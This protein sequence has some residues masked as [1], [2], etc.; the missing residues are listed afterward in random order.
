MGGGDHSV[1]GS[2]PPSKTSIIIPVLDEEKLIGVR[3]AE[4]ATAH[5]HEV[6]VVDGGS[7]DR[8]RELVKAS[9]IA[10]LVEHNGRDVVDG[11]VDRIAEEDQL[12]QRHA[13]RNRQRQPVAADLNELLEDDRPDATD[14]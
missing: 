6:I 1:T 10:R 12:H 9:G 4:L 2:R 13:Q 8:T 5:A 3:L 14:H 7:R 11:G